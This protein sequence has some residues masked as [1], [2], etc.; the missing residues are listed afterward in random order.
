M[1]LSNGH[2]RTILTHIIRNLDIAYALID[3][4]LTIVMAGPM[5]QRWFDA[6][7]LGV[8]NRPLVDVFPE[9]M[10]L[11]PSLSRLFTT[12]TEPFV[13]E[14]VQRTVAGTDHYFNLHFGGLTTLPQA[15]NASA[16]LV[17]ASNITEQA[18]LQQTLT[19]QRNELQLK[20]SELKQVE[21]A[22]WQAA[23]YDTLTNLPN[24][25]LFRRHLDTAFNQVRAGELR[26]FALLFVDLDRF[27][28]IND[29]LGHLVGDQLLVTIA[30]R[31]KEAVR[32]HDV[33]ARLG[34]DEFVVLVRDLS[35]PHDAEQIVSRLHQTISQLVVLEGY[36]I[37]PTASI[38][39]ASSSDDYLEAEEMLR[40]AD[41]AMYAAKNNGRGQHRHSNPRR[42]SDIFFQLQLEADLYRAIERAEFLLHYQPIVLLAPKPYVVGV[43]ALLRWNHP[44]WGVLHPHRFLQLAEEMNLMVAIGSW[45]IQ[46]ACEQLSLWH[47]AGYEQLQLMVNV[48][49]RQFEHDVLLYTVQQALSQYQLAAQQLHLEVVEHTALEDVDLIRPTLEYLQSLGVSIAVDDFGIGTSLGLLKHLLF[50]IIKIDQAFIKA[51]TD[52]DAAIIQAILAMANRL[53]LRVIAE[54]VETQNQLDFLKFQGC[55]EFQGYFFS[56]PL[57]P[58]AL[59]PY[60]Q[61]YYGPPT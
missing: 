36:E 51:M 31:L 53:N 41:L 24:R 34:G 9:T 21:A 26:N 54:G 12:E 23:Y 4:T 16:L 15:D 60:L 22:L 3:S 44:E 5:M 37:F 47:H 40:D 61:K 33:V 8:E 28:V 59:S 27:K 13:L 7:G 2:N 32:G 49:A 50:N 1:A 52:S 35:E 29:S 25:A 10:G 39:I 43:E 18:R 42:R 19:Q 38:G 45:V 55:R 46:T 57:S 58:A 17:V 11:E 48:S 6:H 20:I 30:R 14:K 56:R